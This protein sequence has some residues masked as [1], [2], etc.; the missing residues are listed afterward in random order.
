MVKKQLDI[1]AKRIA[2]AIDKLNIYTCDMTIDDFLWDPKTIDACATTTYMRNHN[3][4]QKILSRCD[5]C[6]W[7]QNYVI[8]TFHIS[9]IY[10]NWSRNSI[11]NYKN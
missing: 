10:K 3:S 5:L 4:N 9:W 1:F 8:E 7:E 2:E 11:Y 6:R